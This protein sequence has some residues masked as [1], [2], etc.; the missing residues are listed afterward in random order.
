MK[1]IKF[2]GYY[3]LGLL[4]IVALS[5]APSL[6]QGEG[7]VDIGLYFENTWNLAKELV[8]PDKWVYQ[9][10][11]EQ[12]N[13]FSFL[14]DPYFYSMRILGAALLLGFGLA[15]ILALLT[16]LLP[17]GIIRIVKRILVLMEAIP[18]LLVAFFFQMFI[19]F[20]YKQS[21]LQLMKFVTL[22][23]ERIFIAPIS[24]LAILPMISLFR[25]ILL[26]ME[27]EL[28]KDYV[29]FALSKGIKDNAII[30]V[31]VL[32]NILKS[33]FY[34]SKIILWGTLSSL[35]VI[36]YIFNIRGLFSFMMEDFR[37]MVIAA[38]LMMVF[39]PF[40]ILY[41]GVEI[42]MEKEALQ[43]SDKRFIHS[44]SATPS[45]PWKQRL[46]D[47]A[48]GL[49]AHFKHP[50]FLV[51]FAI[52]FTVLTIS[53]VHTVIHEE[54]VKNFTLIY[55]DEGNLVS[56]KPH[57]PS[58]YV[59][60]GTDRN[61]YSILDQLL[62]GAKYTI[63]FAGAIAL[64][65]MLFGF[66]LAVPYA[67]F[68]KERWKRRIER[69]IDSF[70]FLPLSV[71]AVILLSPVLLGTTSGFAYSFTER[72]LIE[73]GVLILLIVPLTTV[74]IGNE[75]R[76]I[77]KNEYIDGARVLGG[78]SRH[79]LFRHIMPHLHSKLGIIFGQQF[80]QVLLILIHLGLFNIFLG[81]TSIMLNESYKAWPYSVTFEWSGLI[82]GSRNAFMSGQYWIVVPVFAAFV[83]LILA[84]Q[85][86]IE[87]IQEVQQRRVGVRTEKQRWNGVRKMK[88]AEQAI[89]RDPS[90]GQFVFIGEEEVPRREKQ[91]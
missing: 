47:Y 85:L 21:G 39:T 42:F 1:F 20:I 9:F 36:E 31:H 86:I 53:V 74:L 81:G 90:P 87:G 52:I 30:A 14:W 77:I 57:P 76:L 4:G 40:Y 71:I 37:P 19:V 49:A 18:D 45:M 64:M 50:K 34:H 6:L 17:K 59:L 12:L 69:F 78:N 63:L 10:R 38:A 68:I 24:V 3:V 54:P 82:S 58:E 67:L 16:Q 70:H 72:I 5:S 60:L 88:P 66:L 26:L 28:T 2:F 73:A 79:I 75:I 48:K 13:V 83:L 46:G 29:D 27:E 33:T 23:D 15:F 22:G 7:I 35:F 55:D 25:V 32:R 80:I 51:G 8:Q 89:E 11:Q 91:G 84:M 65:R 62:T 56:S 61:G 43:L 44:F 41:Q